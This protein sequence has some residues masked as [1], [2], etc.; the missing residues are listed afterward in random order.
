MTI[1][2]AIGDYSKDL[3]RAGIG[4][5]QNSV[6]FIISHVLQINHSQLY[7]DLNREISTKDQKTIKKM[8]ARRLRHEPISQII[9]SVKFCDL[10][11]KVNKDVLTPRPETELLVEKALQVITNNR[12][13]LSILD[14]GT[15]SGAIICAIADKSDK[16]KLFASDIS[17]KA[18]K[19]ARENIKRLGFEG[20]IILKKGNLFEPW[21]EEKFDLILTNLPYVPEL[22]KDHLEKDVVNFEPHEGIF[23]GPDGFNLYQ[24]FFS[25]VNQHIKNKGTI[26]CEM[27]PSQSKKIK[28]ICAGRKVRI[29]KDFHGLDRIAI[30]SY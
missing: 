26:I 14:L 11:I 18:L 7:A 23:S 6:L 9:G 13:P 2:E 17:K 5:W 20:R 25:E 16:A 12:Q 4:D 22:Q 1:K 15:G 21:P 19:I 8:I 30:I 3:K 28:K 10:D 24:K 27:D 29:I